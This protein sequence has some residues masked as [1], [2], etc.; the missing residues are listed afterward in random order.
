MIPRLLKAARRVSYTYAFSV[1]FTRSK[2]S[3]LLDFS[4]GA[5]ELV[6]GNLCTF[7]GRILNRVFVVRTGERYSGTWPATSAGFSPPDRRTARLAN[8]NRRKATNVVV[9]GF[10]VASVCTVKERRFRSY[11]IL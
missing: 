9:S 7:H 2:A 11:V 3:F 8:M 1:C 5:F 6:E 10:V 4:R